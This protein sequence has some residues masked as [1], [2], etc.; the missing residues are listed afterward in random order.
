MLAR[1]RHSLL[2]HPQLCLLLAL[3]AMAAQGHARTLDWCLHEGV[4][5]HVENAAVPCDHA[6]A[7]G[8]MVEQHPS[9]LETPLVASND[10]A[11][12]CDSVPAESS[13]GLMVA[14]AADASSQWATPLDFWPAL[15]LLGYLPLDWSIAGAVPGVTEQHRLRVTGTLSADPRPRISGALPGYSSRL[16]I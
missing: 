4:A 2:R 12:H 3:S 7:S 8:A 1:I 9:H 15:E 10:A 6:G 11:N 14:A 13:P 16:L 5:A